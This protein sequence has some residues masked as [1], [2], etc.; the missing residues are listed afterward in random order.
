MLEDRVRSLCEQEKWAEAR[1][2][3]EAAVGKARK[4]QN[5]SSDNKREL[6]L[7][8]EVKGDYFRTV[9]EHVAARQDYKEA[10]EV[11]DSVHGAE[12]AQ[13][14][15]SASVAVLYD[16]DEDIEEAKRYYER[17]I[18]M[19]KRMDPPSNLDVADLNNNLAFIYEE[20]GN[21]DRAETLFLDAL[22]IC[23][24][25]LGPKDEETAVLCNNVGALYQKRGYHEQARAMHVMALEAREETLG[26]DHLETG[27]SHSNLALTLAETGDQ[28]KMGA[29][30]QHF[31]KALEVY[32]KHFS[33]APTD[34]ATVVANYTQFLRNIGDE[35]SIASLEKR[36]A[37]VM[38]KG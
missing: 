17:A 36:A 29:A 28:D 5:G 3:A 6:A 1:E 18:D 8:L 2:A 7:S 30:R 22:K 11:L 24:E 26:K 13:G 35:K 37:K 4:S 15:I 33:E 9:G 10:M 20:L 12:E 32:E 38:R 27:Q 14:R 31:K 23:H 34:Y 21:F 16:E 19:F 25:E